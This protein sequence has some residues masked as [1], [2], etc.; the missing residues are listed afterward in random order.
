MLKSLDVRFNERGDKGKQALRDAVKGRDGFLS[1]AGVE[2]TVCV[3]GLSAKTKRPH[4]SFF[5]AFG[6]SNL[7]GHESLHP[8]SL[9]APP[10]QQRCGGGCA[11]GHHL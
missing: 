6:R 3:D 2:D 10:L 9:H 7:A 5:G 4:T 11:G 8:G 1:V